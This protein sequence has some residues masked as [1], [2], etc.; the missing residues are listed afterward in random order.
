MIFWNQ[1]IYTDAWNYAAHA[2]IG[3][4]VP[5]TDHPY[6]NHIGNVAME[7]M[8]AIAK[9]ASL[10]KP[11]LGIQCALLHDVIEDTDETYESVN[12]NFG[13]EVANGVQALTKNKQLQ[14]KKERMADSLKRIR[15]QPHEVWIVKMA[16][17]ISNLQ[18]P[19]AYWVKLKINKYK[20]EAMIIY[21]ELKD[22]DE[23]LSNRLKGK[24]AFY[25]KYC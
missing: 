21:N 17:R 1:E 2:H 14:T 5:G 6:I 13:A 12:D 24:I 7:V 3:Q 4:K 16:D 25:E 8:T 22:A 20:N 19:P 11:D 10:E 15:L 9:S 23:Y 18:R